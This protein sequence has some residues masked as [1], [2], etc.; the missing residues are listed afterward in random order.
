ML[1]AVPRAQETV[2]RYNRYAGLRKVATICSVT[3]GNINNQSMQVSLTVERGAQ[4]LEAG[5]N[6]PAAPNPVPERCRA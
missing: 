1:I 5:L 3:N 2:V 4:I 6:K